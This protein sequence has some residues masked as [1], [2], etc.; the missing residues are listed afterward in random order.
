MQVSKKINLEYI[1]KNQS[2]R[3]TPLLSTDDFISY[4]QDRGINASKKQLEQFEKLGIFHPIA[5]V[6]YP[7]IK[8]KVEYVKDGREYKY[9]GILKEGEEWSGDIEEKYSYFSFKEDL[10]EWAKEGYL[11]EPSV[12]PFQK[13]ETFVDDDKHKIIDNFYSIFQCYSLYHLIKST[14]KQIGLEDWISYDEDAI[15]KIVGELSKISKFMINFL[16]ENGIREGD[17]AIICQIISNRYFPM[18][19]SDNRTMY[20]RSY[21]DWDWDDCRNKWDG[22][23]VLSDIGMNIETFKELTNLMTH[24]SYYIDPLQNW[25]GLVNFISIEKKKKLKDKALL[26]QTLYSMEKMLRLFYEDATGDKLLAP[27][28]SRDN[29]KE[30]FYGK[31]VVNDKLQYLE[32]LANEYH[33]NPRPKLILVVEGDGEEE[34]IPRLAKELFGTSFSSVGISVMNLKG[35]GGFEG[36]RSTNPYGAL[37]KFIDDYHYR[38]TIVFVILDDEGGVSK[39]KKSLVRAQ[40]KRYPKRKVTKDEYITLWKKNIEF[41]NFSHEEI[42]RAMT[43]LCGNRYL[44]QADEIKHCESIFGTKD[45]GNPLGDLYKDKLDYGLK[46]TELLHLLFGYILL[47]PVEELNQDNKSKRPIIELVRKI[48]DL[49]SLNFQCQS[50]SMDGW[51]ANQDSGYFGDID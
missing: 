21:A 44:F 1:I 46:K 24:D 48:I 49:S 13:W 51:V 43:E 29:W 47:H 8:I 2:F 17:A 15:N 5:R 26:A 45:N 32:F 3:A 22:K 33:L 31:D 35:V 16:L 28:D 9:L 19:Q 20:I 50:F 18:T 4:C 10:D 30:R 38:Q 23:N 41:D 40:S 25:Y 37:E 6:K 42:A 12:K 34:Q 7:K 11:W 27:D 39:I 14:T 36:K